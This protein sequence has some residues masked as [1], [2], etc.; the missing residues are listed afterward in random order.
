VRV[1]AGGRA[2][3]IKIDYLMLSINETGFDFQKRGMKAIVT[4]V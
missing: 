4:T 1:H 2:S 3:V